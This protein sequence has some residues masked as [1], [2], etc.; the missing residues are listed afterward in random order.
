MEHFDILIIGGGAAGIA[1]AKEC[2][3]AKVLL[4]DRKPHLGGV[5]LQCTHHGFGQNQ[6]GI[7]YAA[8]LLTDFP[9][10]ITLAL[11]TTVL[12]VSPEKTALLS[13]RD[14][15]RKEVSFS[16]LI[17]ATGCREIP[18][19]ALPIGGTRPK[20]VYTAG[21]MQEL[22]NLHGYIPEG[23]AVILGS[24]DLGLIMA[25]QL[26]EAGIAVT[27]VE[28]APQC[29]GIPG[30]RRCLKKHPIRLIC[31][32]TVAQLH[33][34]KT[35]LGCT[36]QKGE[37][38]PCR[39]L[40]IAV[41]LR[42]EHDI[43]LVRKVTKTKEIEYNHDARPDKPT[44]ETVTETEEISDVRTIVD[45]AGLKAIS[46]ALRDIKEIQMI[47]SELDREEQQARIDNLR[48]Q[49]DRDADTATEVEVVFLAGE[50]SWNE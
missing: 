12:S 24:G 44:K 5:L 27:L 3:G 34:E 7:D 39:T 31:S 4:A 26:A 15:G 38:I 8:E 40:L 41:G 19:G 46:S 18:A 22:M 25:N 30:N 6:S 35:L 23:P 20:G 47:R 9:E 10:D 32:D 13:G 33:G 21:Q 36:T 1:A 50:D 16:Q 48:R 2:V 42:P 11:N 14:F 29:G 49:A 28:K 17:L 37:Y 45:R 43:Q